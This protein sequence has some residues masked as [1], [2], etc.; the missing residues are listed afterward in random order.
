MILHQHSVESTSQISE[1]WTHLAATFGDSSISIYVNGK[2][3]ATLSDIETL[4]LDSSGILATSPLGSISSDSEITVGA[5]TSI[6][7]NQLRVDNQFSGQYK[8]I[9]LFDFA[10][11][12]SQI[13]EMY[14]GAFDVQEFTEAVVITS[15][16]TTAGGAIQEFDEGVVISSSGTTGA[17]SIGE[18][19]EG[20]VIISSSTTGIPLNGTDVTLDDYSLRHDQIVIGQNVTWTQDIMLSNETQ[21]IAIEVPDDAVNIIVNTMNGNETEMVSYVNA[22]N[23]EIL[24]II[25]ASQTQVLLEQSASENS[26]SVIINGTETP[27]ISLDLV[28][29]MVQEEM[30]TKLVIINDTAYEYSLEFETPAPYAIE[31]DN[32][33][34]LMYNKTVTVAHNST[35]HYTDVKSF[36]EIPE[37]LVEKG[38]QFKLFWNI[39]GTKTDVTNDPRFQVKF[40]DTDGN[41]IVDQMQWIIPQL[42]E[43]EFEIVASIVIINVFS[44]PVVGGNWTVFFE[45]TGKANL[46]ITGYNGTNWYDGKEN[47]N[48]VLEADIDGLRNEL[49]ENQATLENQL[50]ADIKTLEEQIARTTQELEEKLAH[51]VIGGGGDGVVDSTLMWSKLFKTA[52]LH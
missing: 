46:T 40:V 31:E 9:D 23:S 36:S 37:E 16:S 27:V 7:D 42:S 38:A 19:G 51:D 33:D 10:A 3:E 35:L 8:N 6:R 29:D 43:Q 49:A 18:F 44:F 1:N 17:G 32:S 12:Q 25:N 52:E 39:N 14:I 4:S 13:D 15:G 22:T 30:P 20:V 24:Q 41:G 5:L 47:R 48:P 26:T 34:E 28:S 50:Q 2:L 11:D 21:S 45:T